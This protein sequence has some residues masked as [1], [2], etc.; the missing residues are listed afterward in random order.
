MS[1]ESDDKL[2]NAIITLHQEIKGLRGDMDKQLSKIN[3]QLGEHSRSIMALADKIDGLSSD[4]NRYAASNSALVQNH[5]TRLERLE[6]KDM[7]SP[8]LVKE[9]AVKYRKSKKKK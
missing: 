5:E 4:F 7:G 2:T 1:K 6:E 9:P 8:Y 3:L